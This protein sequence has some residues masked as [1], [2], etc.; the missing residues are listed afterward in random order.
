MIRAVEQSDFSRLSE[1]YNY[2][3]EHSAATFEEVAVDGP[4]MGERV[5]K[6]QALSLPWLVAEDSGR[7]TGYAY[8]S[9]WNVR[10]AYR[11][12]V[13]C[14]VYLE[15]TATGQGLGG[16]L[17]AELFSILRGQDLRI[18]IGGVSLPNAASV[19]LHEKFGFEK[20]AHFKE[21]GYKLGR[22]IDVGYWQMSLVD[23]VP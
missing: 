16:R 6:M 12:T 7:V 17:Y 13:E 11:H 22:W 2:Y 8:A 9:P 5:E 3:I 4:Q 18:V 21:V 15:P 14:S 19:A 20:V 1:I 23:S 10:S